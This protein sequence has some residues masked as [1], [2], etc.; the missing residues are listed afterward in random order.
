V[1]D[2]DDDETDFELW[3][4][5][6]A[7]RLRAAG[8][9]LAAALREHAESLIAAAGE[10]DVVEVFGANDVLAPLVLEYAD[11]QFEYTGTGSPFGELEFD[12]LDETESDP[13]DDPEDEPAIP[14]ITVLQRRDYVVTDEAAVLAA[15]R[16]AYRS[17]WP[18]DDEAAAARDVTHLGRAL[19]QAAHAGDGFDD[20]NDMPGL[21]PTGGAVMVIRQDELLSGDPED[22]PQNLFEADGEHLYE[23]QDVYVD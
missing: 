6:G 4:P 23:M 16:A 2:I 18:D 7:A 1:T 14:G 22:W 3:T 20:L 19:Y 11:A 8:E 5:P 15:G 21:A 17:L 9:A 10:Q 12:D 13:E